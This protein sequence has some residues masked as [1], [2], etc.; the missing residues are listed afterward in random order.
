MNTWWTILAAIS[1]VLVLGTY[2]RVTWGNRRI[3]KLI[4]QD[5]EGVDQWPF[6][7]VVVAA[8][9]EQS[10]I[11]AALQSLLHFDYDHYEIIVVDDRST[12][13]TGEI[14]DAMALRNERLTVVHV[15]KLPAG[16]LGKN[17]ALWFGTQHA[18]GAYLLFTDA[19]VFMQQSTLKRSIAYMRRYGVDHLT[20]SPDCEMPSLILQ[21]FVVLF[22]NLFA[23][24]T[25]PWK[26]SDPKSAAFIGIGAFNLVG[27]EVYDAVGTHQTIA[28]RPDDDI[29]LGK[30]IKQHG[31]RQQILAGAGMI[32]VPW[33]ASVRELVSGMEKNAFSGVDYRITMVVLATAALLVLDVWPFLA[34]WIL[35]GAARYL[36]LATVLVLLGHALQTARQMR[37]SLWSA[38]LFPVAVLLMIYIQ[39]RAMLLTFYSGGIRWR[40]T[41]Y[42]LAELKANKI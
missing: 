27:R 28:M 22:V 17:H 5:A 16:W 24:Y 2:V 14:L 26:V 31:Y 4:E 20:A 38:V 36:Y 15:D 25:R 12:D 32:R 33:Y 40:D 34:I 35:G 42:S 30:I 39:W 19:D 29:K 11:A 18:Q 23:L 10:H 41:H 9:N 21:A 6:V 13:Q 8:R 1:F 7:S 3:G 37:Q